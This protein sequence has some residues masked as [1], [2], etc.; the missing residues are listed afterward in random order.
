MMVAV[1]HDR[2]FCIDY[3]DEDDLRSLRELIRNGGLLE[4]RRWQGILNEI[5]VLLKEK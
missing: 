3:M 1:A 4:S 2:C 5:N